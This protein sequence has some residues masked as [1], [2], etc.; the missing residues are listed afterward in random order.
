MRRRTYQPATENGK[1]TQ[2]QPK[3]DPPYWIGLLG[4][5][6]LI[7][8]F[9]GLALLLYS[10][11]KYR[12]TKLLVIGV[13]CMLFT[14]CVYYSL[15]RFSQ[16]EMALQTVDSIAQEELNALVAHVEFYKLEN[17][18]YPDS[19]PQLSGSGRF[20]PIYDHSQLARYDKTVPFNYE[21]LGDK[22]LLFSSGPDGIPHTGDDIFPQ[23]KSGSD[24]IG[25]TKE[26]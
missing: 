16:S 11:F 23:L 9:V 6:P 18:V 1:D 14:V 24:Q 5:I 25:W 15:Y 8:F 21:N 17:G 7:G 2:V 26:R 22:Y 12:N 20:V 19:L 3:A 10:I 4:L 13:A